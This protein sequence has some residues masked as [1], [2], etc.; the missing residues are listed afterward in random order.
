[1]RIYVIISEEPVFHPILAEGLVRE[2]APSHEIVGITLAIGDTR[3]IGFAPRIKETIGMFGLSAFA[4]LALQSTIYKIFAVLGLRQKGAPFSVKRVAAQHGIPCVTSWNVNE[5]A[6]T[7]LLRSMRPDI[8][9]SS[10]GHIFRKELLAIPTIAC[11]NR[12]TSLLPK[13]GGLWP[14]FQAMLHGEGTIGQT[15]HTMTSRIDRGYIL[16]QEQFAVDETSTFYGI[17][18][19]SFRSAPALAK[20][21][22]DNLL[23]GRKTEMPVDGKSYFSH[24]T[25]AEGKAFRLKH[26]FFRFGELVR[27][28]P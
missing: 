12:H 18:A 3:R 6:H 22:I 26:R 27:R 19:K 4:C 8:I 10:N 20:L 9:I 17:Y 21:G 23:D 15:I 1:M 13:Y 7:A 14:V 24:P 2:L 11:I 25:I 16:A 28:C 5:P